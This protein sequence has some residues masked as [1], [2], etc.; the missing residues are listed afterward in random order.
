MASI[1]F[2]QFLSQKSI[3]RIFPIEQ[4]LY[5]MHAINNVIKSEN[6]RKYIHFDFMNSRSMLSR[7]HKVKY[8]QITEPLYHSTTQLISHTNNKNF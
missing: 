1:I 6:V 8:Q 3:V 4:K 2:T 7:L 5:F